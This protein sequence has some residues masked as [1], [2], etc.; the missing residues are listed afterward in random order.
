[1][2][3]C[4]SHT[5]SR[6]RKQRRSFDLALSSYINCMSLTTAAS[7]VIQARKML[8][9]SHGIV[10]LGLRVRSWRP[11]RVMPLTNEVL[12]FDLSPGLA[13]TDCGHLG[14][15][16]C[17]SAVEGSAIKTLEC[18][19]SEATGGRCIFWPFFLLSLIL[20]IHK[21]LSEM[22]VPSGATGV[23]PYVLGCIGKSRME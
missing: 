3:I 10:N 7:T 14:Q 13:S 2:A 20:A 1:M 15:S 11:R 19:I 23:S 4:V 9:A 17:R 21:D 22:V 5:L 16:P 6:N 18:Q 12:C 8:S